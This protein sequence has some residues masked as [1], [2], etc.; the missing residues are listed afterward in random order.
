MHIQLTIHSP[1]SE[2]FEILVAELS[3]L[4]Y[5]GF[6]EETDSLKAFVPSRDFDKPI[7]EGLL[8]K[9]KALFSLDWKYTQVE[10]ENWNALWESNFEPVSISGKLNIRALFHPHDASYPMEIVI[11]PKMAFGTGHHATTSNICEFLLEMD[12]HGKDVFDFGTGTGILAILAQ[13]LG[14]KE[15][16]AVDNDPV[17]V[18]N[19]H[20]NFALNNTP[21]IHL[22]LGDINTLGTETLSE[23][24]GGMFDL[25][26][27]NITRNVILHYLAEISNKLKPSALFLASGFYESDLEMLK[28]AAYSLGLHLES[29][30]MKDGWCAAS[31]RKL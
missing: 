7:T 12:L 2:A 26:I 17:C 31:F 23:P 13:K 29:T 22:A 16:W 30:K 15:V 28:S 10:D 18:E 19:S 14:A 20:E 21:E 24:E 1:L 25:I 6:V 3:E 8:E 5:E 27:G 11:Q 4:N 9:Y